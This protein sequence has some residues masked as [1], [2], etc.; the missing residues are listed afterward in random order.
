M[1][2][3]TEFEKEYQQRVLQWAHDRNIIE[4]SDAVRQLLKT[5]TEAKE[6]VESLAVHDYKEVE[7]AIGDQWV[8]VVIGMAQS[9]ISY[10]EAIDHGLTWH[11]SPELFRVVGD[12]SLLTPIIVAVGLISDGILKGDKQILSKGYGTYLNVLRLEQDVFEA[13]VEKAWNT[14]KDRKGKMVNGVFVKEQDLAGVTNE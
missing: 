11:T 1:T 6:F 13:A 2:V 9:A 10:Q 8:T 7:D 5:C 3:M 12:E 4:G 14:I